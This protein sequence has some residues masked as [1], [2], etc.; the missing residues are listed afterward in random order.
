MRYMVNLQDSKKALDTAKK[1][2]FLLKERDK[3]LKSLRKADENTPPYVKLNPEHGKKIADAF[4]NMKHEP[5]NPD[6]KAAYNSLINETGQQFKD[7]MAGGLKISRIKPDQ[8]NPYKTSQD[9]HK[10]I[11]SGH[12]WYYPTEEGFGGD[13]Q[14]Q[15]HP[16]LAETELR[17]DGQP[18]LANDIFRIVHDVNGHH[19]GGKTTFGPKG[20][21]QAYLTHKK[22]YSPLA[23]K[24]LA[25]ETLGQ[26]SWVCFGPYGEH[27]RKNPKET[28]YAEQKAAL[29]PDWIVNGK[30]HGEE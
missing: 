28:I 22:M 27:N 18:L 3:L 29:A 2:N 8:E 21:H 24:A 11:A 14:S 15:D 1:I 23:Q 6:V 30:W 4:E 12:L 10:D 13:D 17:H 7:I 16:L 19:L 25:T 20:E 5:N 26:N 9:M